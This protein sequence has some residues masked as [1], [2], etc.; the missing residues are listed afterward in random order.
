MDQLEE[1]NFFRNRLNTLEPLLSLK[2]K[3]IDSILDVTRAI[4]QNI[5]IEALVRI[6]E[7]VIHAQLGI[8]KWLL[9]IKNKEGDWQCISNQG[10]NEEE[11][12]LQNIGIFL[13][14]FLHFEQISVIEENMDFSHVIPVINKDEKIAFAFLGGFDYEEN[15]DFND[16]LKF[17]QTVTNMICV[18]HENKRL[19][20]QE[21]EQKLQKKD[22]ILAS[23]IQ[24]VLV[25]KTFPKSEK[26][27]V[28]ALYKPFREI[29]GDYY[30]FIEFS[31]DEYFMCMCDISGKGIA[32]AMIMS[33]FQANLRLTIKKGNSLP[34]IIAE[35]NE[36]VY[37][38]TRGDAFITGFF[39]KYNKKNNSLKYINAGHNPPLLLQ[40]GITH[41][42]G[43]GCSILGALKK[44]PSII[45]DTIYLSNDAFLVMYTDGLT[46]ASDKDDNLYGAE[47]L[48]KF[49]IANKQEDVE[50]FIIKLIQEIQQFSG[51]DMFDDDISLMCIKFD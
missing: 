14:N 27:K 1:I 51:K 21:T 31:E 50:F 24:N 39:A 45:A 33:N 34:Q 7:A 41:E 32:A 48:Q 3:Q 28:S 17:V 36:S 6:L 46:E 26:F 10:I 8:E 19:Y 18:A 23:M 49:A 12:K 35:L 13:S 15:N 42:L 11:L 29:G 2:Q 20:E 16:R 44:L 9:V 40:S 30:D 43:V 5:P 25:P 37:E 47:K 22:I 38:V 4:N